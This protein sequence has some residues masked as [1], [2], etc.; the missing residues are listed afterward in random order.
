MILSRHPEG[1]YYNVL[2]IKIISVFIFLFTSVFIGL[3][4]D[5]GASKLTYFLDKYKE[6]KDEVLR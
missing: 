3:K 1:V 5:A 4:R 2:V 6:K